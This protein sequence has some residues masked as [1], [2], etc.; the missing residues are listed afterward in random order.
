MTDPANTGHTSH[1]LVYAAHPKSTYRTPWARAHI[2]RLRELLPA[3]E[4]IDPEDSAWLS[5][6]DWLERW[7]ML[8]G[9]LSEVVVFAARDN[10]VGAGCLREVADA[11]AYGVPV[12]ALD[13]GRGLCELRAL[14][15]LPDATA[16]RAARLVLG[17]PLVSLFGSRPRRTP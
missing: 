12:A 4:V 1:P 10:T 13:L 2:G 16:A 5:D 3:A 15:L 6:A 8:L 17:Q 7:P 14:D 9:R 11:I